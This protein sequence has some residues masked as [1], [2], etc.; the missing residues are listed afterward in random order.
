MNKLQKTYFQKYGYEFP[1][2]EEKKIDYLVQ[3]NEGIRN[4]TNQIA[5]QVFR[6]RGIKEDKLTF[7]QGA[8]YDSQGIAVDGCLLT[9]LG[10]EFCRE[11]KKRGYSDNHHSAKFKSP[12]TPETPR[13]EH[14][15]QNK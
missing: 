1:L 11:C 5:R 8:W 6:P 7:G 3:E 10:P 4:V 14:F 13:L 12:Y 2:T 15:N 9:Y